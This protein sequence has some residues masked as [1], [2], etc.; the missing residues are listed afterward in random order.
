M[1]D[2]TT[3]DKCAACGEEGDGLKFCNGCKLVKYCSRDCQAT[4]RPHHKK[5]CKKRAAEL[6]DEKLFKE[7]EPDVGGPALGRCDINKF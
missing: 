4:H 7:V 5:A 3:I 2:S 1:M 6:Y